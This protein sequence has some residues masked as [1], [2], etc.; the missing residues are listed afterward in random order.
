[1][2]KNIEISVPVFNEEEGIEFFL[3]SLEPILLPLQQQYEIQL[4]FIND[5]SIDQA[6]SIVRSYPWKLQHKPR[7]IHL[8]KNLGHSKATAI[9]VKECAAD[10]LIIIDS[11]M[12][13]DP[14]LIP[15][16]IKE[17]EGGAQLV[18]VRRKKRYDGVIKNFHFAL[19]Y[20]IFSLLTG[21]EAGMGSFGL[22]SRSVLS[23]ICAFRG[24]VFFLPGIV[25][26]TKFPTKVLLADRQ[27][28]KVGTSK[29]GLWRL[30]KLAVLVLFFFS[31]RRISNLWLQDEQLLEH[32]H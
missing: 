17:W 14:N 12:Q 2:K 9:C 19:F 20:K 7:I 11:D 31:L 10:A 3:Q 30:Y 5:A 24:G 26:L 8:E 28:R 6:V 1:M 15:I 13:D 27:A 29:M 22:Y 4:S 16:M 23:A 18:R 25:S 32:N 21:L